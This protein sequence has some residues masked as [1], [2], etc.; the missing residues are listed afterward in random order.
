[1]VDV[2]PAPVTEFIEALASTVHQLC[3][4]EG[5]SIPYTVIREVAENFIHAEFAEPVVSIL[6]AG[7]TIRFADQG[8][9]ISD[10]DRALLPGFTTA[11]GDMKH[12]IRGVGSGLPIVRE[13]LIHSGGSLAI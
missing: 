3:R 7:G 12:Y 11:S 1:V 6:D 5:G 8:P 2:D 9:G 13:Y 10:K 4:A